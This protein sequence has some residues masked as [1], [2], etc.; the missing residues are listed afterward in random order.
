MKGIE[1]FQ[2]KFANYMDSFMCLFGSNESYN[3]SSLTH[4]SFRAFTAV[5]KR[6]NV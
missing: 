5:R 1:E 2:I 3:T 4:L 6:A